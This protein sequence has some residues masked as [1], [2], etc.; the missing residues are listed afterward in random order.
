L[1]LKSKPFYIF[2]GQRSQ[3]RSINIIRS[4]CD[5]RALVISFES[6]IETP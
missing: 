6:I 5:F 3:S 2:A 4:V 1:I